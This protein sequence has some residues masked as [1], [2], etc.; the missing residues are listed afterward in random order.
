MT[1]K[2]IYCRMP[3]LWEIIFE[4]KNL[5][6][7]QIFE[8]IRKSDAKQLQKIKTVKGDV[9]LDDLGIDAA[10]R[11]QLVDNVDVVFHC[12]ANVR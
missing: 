4:K 5:I 9:S 8:N 1:N 10:D 11:T 3:V 12:A 6:G 2:F 7:L